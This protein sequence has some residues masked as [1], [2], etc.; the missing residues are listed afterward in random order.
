MRLVLIIVPALFLAVLQIVAQ[1]EYDTWFFGER[2]GVQF[3]GGVP[4]GVLG[5]INTEEGSSVWSDPTSG[6]PILSTDGNIVYDGTGSVLNNGRGLRGGYSS[7]NSAMIVPD[8]GNADKYYIFCAGDLSNSSNLDSIFTVSIAD[9]RG[10]PPGIIVSKND[11]L[12][13]GTAEKIAGTVHCDGE[14][15][16]VVTHDTSRPRFYVFRVTKTGIQGPTTYDI[17]EQYR[18]P[19]G[20]LGRQFGMGSLKFSASGR[21]LAMA[22]PFA[23]MCE[24]FDFDIFSGVISNPRRVDSADLYYGLSFSPNERFLYSVCWNLSADSSSPIYQFDLQNSFIKY[25]VG[26]LSVTKALTNGGIQ[27]GPDG[28]IYVVNGNSLRAIDSPNLAGSA[29]AFG[30][31]IPLLAGTMGLTGLP[32]IMDCVLDDSNIEFCAPPIAGI[33]SPSVTCAGSCL[34]FTDKSRRKPAEWY[35]EFEGGLPSTHIGRIPPAVCYPTGGTFRVRLITTNAWGAD[36][37]VTEIRIVDPPKVNAGEDKILCDSSY[38]RLNATGAS[39]YEWAPIAGLNN[40]FV[41]DPIVRVFTTTQYV[42]RGWNNAGCYADDTVM[43]VVREEPYPT[44]LFSVNFLRGTAGSPAQLVITKSRVENVTNSTF[45]I[46]IPRNVFI[47]DSIRKGIEVNSEAPAFDEQVLTIQADLSADTVVIINGTLLLNSSQ[48]LVSALASTTDLCVNVAITP[49]IIASEACGADLRMIKSGQNSLSIVNISNN[50]RLITI[51]GNPRASFELTI[52]TS[53][54]EL[55]ARY[56]DVIR[57]P[58][59][60]VTLNQHFPKMMFVVLRSGEI[61]T[62]VSVFNE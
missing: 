21:L 60:T 12:A 7:T 37:A 42:V 28:K 10:P 3:R 49:G 56:A 20:T 50:G 43:V 14:S 32:T 34:T 53:T 48:E 30:R 39:R 41:P 52:W 51:S 59:Q 23:R 31:Q 45:A 18:V 6:A 5:P 1:R 33:A 8:P 11:T 19:P 2:A 57:E 24:I 27:R 54:G 38:G 29:C 36:T 25:R 15:W 62:M 4:V 22:S 58:I 35:W 61:S 55:L 47:A 17:G 13:T 40:Q 16:W 26:S 44:D 9:M 46:T